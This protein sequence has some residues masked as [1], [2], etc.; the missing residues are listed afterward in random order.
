MGTKWILIERGITAVNSN[1]NNDVVDGADDTPEDTFGVKVNINY[2][3]FYFYD[4]TRKTRFYIIYQYY[5]KK[6]N[7]M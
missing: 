6:L 7:F 2:D 5:F 3:F 4:N 1:L